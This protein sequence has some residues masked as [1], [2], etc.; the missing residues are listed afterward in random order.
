MLRL[1][2]SSPS[3]IYSEI[4]LSDAIQELASLSVCIPTLHY[5]SSQDKLSFHHNHNED[6]VIAYKLLL[7]NN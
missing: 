4:T 6:K 1:N 3:I 7:N 2:I 5:L